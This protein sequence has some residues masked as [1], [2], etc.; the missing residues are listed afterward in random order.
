MGLTTLVRIRGVD[1]GAIPPFGRPFA[2][3]SIPLSAAG[4]DVEEEIED[5]L[6]NEA[7]LRCGEDDVGSSPTR[8][9]L[10][11]AFGLS[12][13]ILSVDREGVE[14]KLGDWKRLRGRALP[15]PRQW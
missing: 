8:L 4:A 14:P 3:E 5:P 12:T 1:G 15:P 11:S 6:A 10:L 13:V 9:L 7:P 2:V